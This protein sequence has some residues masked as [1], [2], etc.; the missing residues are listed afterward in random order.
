MPKL[1]FFCEL[2]PE[3]LSALFS[4]D[5]LQALKQLR[6]HV[7]L[8][9]LDFDPRRAQ[10]VQL[11]H[12]EGIPVIAWLLL[13]KEEG[14]WFNAENAPQAF[15]RY[16]QF[17]R[18]SQENQLHWSG[19]GIDIEPHWH[20]VRALF[21]RE[22]QIV[23]KGI[24]RL[25]RPNRFREAHEAYLR[26]FSTIHQDGFSIDTYILPFIIDERRSRSR[27]LQLLFG[28][29]DLPADREVL[30]LYSSLF[31]P[32][33][34]GILGSYAKDAQSIGVGS[35]GG[36]VDGDFGAFTPLT[37]EEFSRDLRLAW[38]YT[39]DIHIF[40]LE[41]CV[42]QDFLSRLV[43]FTWDE[44]ILLPIRQ[45]R[46]C[47]LWR[48]LGRILLWNLAHPLVPLTILLVAL[49]ARRMRKGLIRPASHWC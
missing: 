11:L 45:A 25:L 6:A 33:G 10:T 5:V 42:R 28:L 39:D 4:E 35:T 37:W 32:H 23:K 36:G 18:W 43:K 46:Q 2:P 44:L 12:Q 26:L 9:I 48:G 29:V 14:Y 15:E 1:T 49:W 3:E 41:G 16:Q 22:W 20:E 21:K 31:R 19:V 24:D 13:P 8:G 38:H 7:S 47:D 17:R 27:V 34:L 40:S 30:M